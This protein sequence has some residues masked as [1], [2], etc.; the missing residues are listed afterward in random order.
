[1]IKILTLTYLLLL[2]FFFTIS[3]NAQV[4]WKS[5]G[6]IIGSDGEI[7]KES[8]GARFQKQLLNPTNDWPK[9]TGTGDGIQ[10]NYFG[11]DI[12]IPGTP[13][14]RMSGIDF[15][16]DY[17]LKLAELNLFGDAK[18]MQ[19]FI[20]EDSLKKAKS[21][22]E[23]ITRPTVLAGNDGFHMW[24]CFRQSK[25]FRG[26]SG[27][28]KIGYAYSQDLITWDRAADPI[29]LKNRKFG[30]WA[31]NMQAYPAAIR[32][33]ENKYLFYNGNGFGMAGFG[34]IKII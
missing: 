34:V 25:D 28:Y 33:K 5:D 23:A 3:S 11:N 4:V 9:A 8:Y 18:E 10:Q 15:G 6:T 17:S 24:F 27:S 16:S 29:A 7:K 19:K 12:F 32:V 21:K 2:F 22:E 26:G 1:M 31:G 13:L 14:L 20:I 30:S